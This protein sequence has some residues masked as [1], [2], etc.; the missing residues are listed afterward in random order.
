[1]EEQKQTNLGIIED[2]HAYWIWENKLPKTLCELLIS[3]SKTFN[4]PT[5]GVHLGEN[6]K[7]TR[8]NKVTWAPLNHWME[9]ILL[10]HA[11]YANNL[12]Q[13][14]YNVS[15]SEKLQISFYQVG[16]Y[17]DWHMDWLKDLDQSNNDVHYTRKISM[18]CLLND[19]SEFEG[20]E[21]QFGFSEKLKLEQG[22]I[23]AFPSFL[24]HKVHPVTSG[25]RISA[26]SWI[27]GDQTF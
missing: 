25:T 20:G 26:V 15:H 6:N 22:T 5:D 14:N 1:M 19:S 17:Y 4:S 2:K 12:A 18:V 23:I 21:F 27:L 9:G 8:N 11:F 7:K 3:E 16:N 24:I 10:T 13:W